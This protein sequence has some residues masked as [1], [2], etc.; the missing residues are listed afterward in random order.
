MVQHIRA[1]LLN[2]T[3]LPLRKART[4]FFEQQA[5]Q[6]LT[7]WK[8]KWNCYFANALYYHKVLKITLCKYVTIPE[9]L[10]PVFLETLKMLIDQEP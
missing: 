9:T 1:A 3:L 6:Y 7:F 5:D 2:D 4:I 8:K 10:Q